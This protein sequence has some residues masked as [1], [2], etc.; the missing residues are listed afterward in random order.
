MP[1]SPNDSGLN[2]LAE[3]GIYAVTIGIIVK[4]IDTIVLKFNSKKTDEAIFR[5]DLMERNEQLANQLK[6]LQDIKLNLEQKVYELQ[7]EF[8]Q[9]R[10]EQL[11]NEK[12]N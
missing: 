8:L 6:D 12:H 11:K 9:F 2:P 7:E 3:G 4:L 1:V 5:K 10:A